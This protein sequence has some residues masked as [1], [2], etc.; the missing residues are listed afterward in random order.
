MPT[1]RVVQGTSAVPMMAGGD[2]SFVDY[3]STSPQNEA[4]YALHGALGGA[5]LGA[6][7]VGGAGL[8]TVGD[9]PL[10]HLLPKSP[11]ILGTAVAAAVLIPAAVQATVA[12][13]DAKTHNAWAKGILDDLRNRQQNTGPT[14]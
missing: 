6:M 14:F 5:T 12:Y 9:G 11:W 8:L 1:P 3:R 2:S 13:L 4:S 7:V 10:T